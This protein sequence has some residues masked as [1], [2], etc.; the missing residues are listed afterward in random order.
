VTSPADDAALDWLLPASTR[1]RT[2]GNRVA[3]L[4]HGATYFRRLCEVVGRTEAGDRV[5]FTD[6]RGDA[7]E[8]LASD[9]PEVEDLFCSAAR[10]GVDVRALLWRS[11]SDK[12]SFSAQENQRLGRRINDAGGQALL[13]QRVR[14]GGSHHQKL[15]VVR[16]RQRPQDDVAFVGGIDLCH[17]RR[18]D[19]EHLGDPQQQPM[20][21]RYG[22]RAPWHDAMVE[23]H[24]PAV[25]DVLDTFLERWNDPTP[26]DRR[27]PYR[28][29]LQKKAHMP[30]RPEPPPDPLDPPPVAGPHTV[31]ILRTYGVKRPAYPFAPRG[32]RTVALAYARAFEQARSL[33]YVEDQYLWSELVAGTLADALRREPGLHVVIVVPRYPDA[34]GRLSG[35]PNRLG[36]LRA[37]EVLAEAGGDRVAVYDLENAAGTPIYVHAKL[38]VVDDVWM[39]CGSDNFNRRSWTHD[40]EATCA[41]IDA[42]VDDRAP[43]DLTGRGLL[44]RRLP[45]DLRLQLWSEH[46]GLPASDPQLLDPAEGFALWR[47]RACDLDEWHRSGRRG[48]RPPG[49]ARAHRPVPVGGLARV[50]ATPLYRVVFDPDGRPLRQRRRPVHR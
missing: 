50:W 13:D 26:L 32:E 20:D 4:V 45:R 49:Q 5:V 29:V 35:P 22:D 28:M 33:V 10:R 1:P 2:G 43:T 39:T 48:P 3:P 12:T 42:E 47:S 34:D 8:L 46:L 7:D 23:I 17:G 31:Q 38:C 6:W 30:R 44:A 14:R 16:H 24:G 25:C 15:V 21:D 11:H 41:V 19:A 18:D 37:M 40:S 9:G 36:Q 27:T